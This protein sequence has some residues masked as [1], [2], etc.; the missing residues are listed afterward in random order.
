MLVELLGMYSVNLEVTDQWRIK[1][2]AFVKYS[3]KNY[4]GVW[5]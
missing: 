4:G 2:F 1:K 3:R 5:G